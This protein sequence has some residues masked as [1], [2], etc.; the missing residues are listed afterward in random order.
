M[1]QRSMKPKTVAIAGATG[2]VGKELIGCLER[3]NFPVSRLKLLASERSAGKTITF[4]GEAVAVETLAENS[5]AGID[6]ALFATDSALSKTFVPIA[7]RA[8]AVAIDNSSAYRMEPDVPLVIPEI[9]AG[10]IG[11]HKG[12]IAN[13][14]CTAI[15]TITPLWPIHRRNRVQRMVFSTYQAASGA[16]QPAMD[17]LFE[18][19]K[20]F[21]EGRAFEP[22]VLPHPYAFNVFSHNDKIDP[23]TGYNYEEVKAMAESKKIFAE[24]DLLISATC[25]RVPVMRAHCISLSFTCEKPIA[26]NEVRAILSD[27]PGVKIVDDR[28]R[29]YFPMPRDASGQDLILV[30]RIRQDLSDPSGR[31]ISWFA[32]GD[33]LLKGAA[34]NAVQIAELL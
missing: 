23:V 1:V 8:G 34:L 21:V 7:V 24:P 18:S 2:A 15:V 4:R 28:E 20:A 32:S 25:I 19:T 11:R 30:G 12:I 16:G 31:T 10:E 29:N 27:A 14:N 5:F 3:R 17:E 13:P 9:N 33:Q 22:K 6:V 26:P